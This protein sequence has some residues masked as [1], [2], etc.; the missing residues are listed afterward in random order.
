MKELKQRSFVIEPIEL[1][2]KLGLPESGELLDIKLT[3]NGLIHIIII[4]EA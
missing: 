4:G 1:N 2:K 3:D